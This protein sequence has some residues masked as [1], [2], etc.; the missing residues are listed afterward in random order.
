MDSHQPFGRAGYGCLFDFTFIQINYETA[1]R[2]KILRR[3]GAH[4]ASRKGEKREKF[5]FASPLPLHHLDE[6]IVGNVGSAFS[7][8]FIFSFPFSVSARVSSFW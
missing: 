6:Y 5:C 4:Q 1:R 8:F 7:E 2:S 3:V